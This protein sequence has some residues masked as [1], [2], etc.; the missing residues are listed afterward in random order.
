MGTL[1]IS[2]LLDFTGGLSN[3]VAPHLIRPNEAREFTN[4]D[5]TYGSLKSI[6]HIYSTSM[7]PY[8]FFYEFRDTL[9]QYDEWRANAELNNIWYWTNG[10]DQGKVLTDGSEY[11]LGMPTP[12]NQ[13]SATVEGTTPDGSLKGSLKYCYTF[14]NSATGTEGPPSPLSAYAYPDEQV[15]RVDNFDT[16]PADADLFRL[17]RIGGYLTRFTLVKELTATDVLTGWVDDLSERDVDGRLLETLNNGLPPGNIDNFVEHG[18]RLFGSSGSKLYYSA[19]GNGDSWYVYDFFDLP[20]TITAVAKTNSGVL[21]MGAQFTSLLEGFSPQ[22]FRL[23]TISAHA[24]CTSNRSLNYIQGVPIWLS[25]DGFY[26]FNGRL[27]NITYKRIKEITGL[28]PSSSIVHNDTY[29]LTFTPAMKP[30]D[31]LYPSESLYPGTI[32]GTG[33]V[34]LADG[35]IYIDFKRGAGFSYGMKTYNNIVSI[36]T[37]KNQLYI[38]TFNKIEY[39]DDCDTVINCDDLVC[40]GAYY[41]SRI[42]TVVGNRYKVLRY[43]SPRLIDG[44][45]S[46]LKEYDKIRINFIGVFTVKVIFDD[47]KVIVEETIKSKAVLSDVSDDIELLEDSLA[48]IGIPN[49][50]NKSYS[51]AFDIEGFGVIKSIQYSWKPRELP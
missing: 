41:M 46:T 2:E 23:R 51:L 17:Y 24:G 26:T 43:I 47:N 28:D 25:E 16:L 33:E 11:G 40:E 29:Y 45:Y 32:Q 34:N 8:Q 15:I 37:W 42:D 38:I 5:I 31:S 4:I 35:L 27:V 36:G 19:T 13:P 20:G 3:V 1:Q 14:Y 48:I 9:H 30:S 21:I 39:I 18:G 44:S 50:Q 10:T 7:V 12:V 22:T 49:N 6:P